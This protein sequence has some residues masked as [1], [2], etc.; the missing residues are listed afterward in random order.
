MKPKQLATAAAIALLTVPMVLAVQVKAQRRNYPDCNPAS[1]Q[2]PVSIAEMQTRLQ[3]GKAA[4][5]KLGMG[6]LQVR[7]CIDDL[8]DFAVEAFNFELYADSL[9][10]IEQSKRKFWDTA[11]WGRTVSQR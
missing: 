7:F 5:A 3:A 1:V 9:A 6:R 4:A 8:G 10:Q 11:A 2:I